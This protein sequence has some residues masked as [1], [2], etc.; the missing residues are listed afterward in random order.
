MLFTRD[1]IA[2]YV[3][4]G[5]DASDL[6]ERLTAAGLAIEGIEEADGDV[7]YD[8]D[9][10]T[11]RPDCMNHLGLA[12]E[13]ADYAE[14]AAETPAPEPVVEAAAETEEAPEAAEAEEAPEAGDEAEEDDEER[15]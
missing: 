14:V 11:N 15:S 7:I 5:G 3:E 8:V 13:A 9:V 4:L 1:W 6:A 2:D 10:T 12:R